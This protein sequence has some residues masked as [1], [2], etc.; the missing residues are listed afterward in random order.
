[1]ASAIKVQNVTFTWWKRGKVNF[2]D[3]TIAAWDLKVDRIIFMT[4]VLLRDGIFVPCP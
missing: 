3:L 4:C 1:M 2:K